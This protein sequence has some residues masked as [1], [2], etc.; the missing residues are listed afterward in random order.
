MNEKTENIGL[1]GAPE[2]IHILYGNSSSGQRYFKQFF[3][4]KLNGFKLVIGIG[5]YPHRYQHHV[6]TWSHAYFRIIIRVYK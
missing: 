1:L 4:I 2:I 3:A 5:M 6:I